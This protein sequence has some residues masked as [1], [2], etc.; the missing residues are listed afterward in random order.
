MVN[1]RKR[2]EREKILENQSDRK[3][4]NGTEGNGEKIFERGNGIEGRK[5]IF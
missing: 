3:R 4:G 1:E 2:G 5:M